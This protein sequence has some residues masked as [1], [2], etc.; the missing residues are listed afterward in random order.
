MT[1]VYDD[2]SRLKQ[3]CLNG[4]NKSFIGL[5]NA[6]LITDVPIDFMSRSL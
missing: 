3:M 5:I 1:T 6:V 4:K 2:V